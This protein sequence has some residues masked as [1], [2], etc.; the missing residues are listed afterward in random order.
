VPFLGWW[1]WV[2]LESRQSNEQASKHHPSMA[3]VSAPASRFLP[4]F[5]FLPSLLDNELLYITLSEINPFLPKFFWS[6]FFIT[7]MVTLTKILSG[8]LLQLSSTCQ[9]MVLPTSG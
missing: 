4:C 8:F 1:P 5:E 2:L 6:C 9:G 7:A 3:S